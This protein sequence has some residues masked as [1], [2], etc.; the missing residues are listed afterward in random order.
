M[1]QKIQITAS[2]EDASNSEIIKSF[3]A[4]K[5]NI[6]IEEISDIRI[7]R[8]S[9]DARS[10]EPKINLTLNVFCGEKPTLLKADFNYQNVSGKPEV[11]IVGSGPAGL[12]AS[13][14]LIELG[15]KPVIL[16]R[17]KSV[18]ERK[19]DIAAMIRSKTVNSESNYCYGEGGAGTFSDGKLYTRSDKRGNVFGILQRFHFHGADDK[20]LYES[21]PHI[22]TD[23]LPEI[24]KNMSRTI[25]ECGG[26]IY[27]DSK[28]SDI[29]ISN[30]KVS[31]VKCANGN[32]YEAKA[33]ALAT[34]HSAR[35]IYELLDRKNIKTEAKNF[36]VGVRV[37]HPQSLIDLIQY[38][39]KTAREFL[40]AAS[41]SLT[42]QSYGRGVY[43][44]CMCPGGY[45]VPA[46]TDVDE[47]VVNGMSSSLRHTAFASSGIVVE[48][49]IED[50][51]DFELYKNF[52]GLEFQRQI[53]KDAFANGGGGQTAPAQRLTDFVNSKYSSFLPESSYLAGLKTSALHE[54]L[55]HETVKRLQ[56][57]FLIFDKKMRGFF[58]AEALI[59]GVE[60]RSS[61]PVRIPRNENMQHVDV[62]KLFVCGEGAG[63]AGGITSSAM[64]GE[65]CAE[66]IK[67]AIDK[68]Q[69]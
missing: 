65:K 36:A 5:L 23:K 62:E 52:C 45:I 41:Y 58:T 7:E 1:Q 60:S 11:V 4:Q 68:Q 53:E 49:R 8:K 44:F 14:R 57:A 67:T 21:H 37:E 55:P 22:G 10:R 38:H 69:N 27:F 30:R 31:G 12:F 66:M 29:I 50:L 33:V 20:I 16:E 32:I 26:E 47:I 40:P 3:A 48:T 54:W 46:S 64:D 24:V 13:L 34:G 18:S 39:S 51:K 19:K 15:L 35:D 43:S 28:V 63:Y 59:V 2:P 61:S 42:A 9:I 25:V 17:G 6:S 56:E